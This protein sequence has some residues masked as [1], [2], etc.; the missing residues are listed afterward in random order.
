MSTKPRIPSKPKLTTITDLLE[1][2]KQLQLRATAKKK[3]ML[4]LKLKE[5]ETVIQYAEKWDATV[6]EAIRTLLNKGIE[7]FNKWGSGAESDPTSVGRWAPQEAYVDPVSRRPSM[8]A[9]FT[10]TPAYSPE[11]KRFNPAMADRTVHSVET[12]FDAAP[13]NGNMAMIFPSGATVTPKDVEA[14]Y[15]PP[16]VPPEL[17]DTILE[18]EL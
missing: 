16:P 5:Y 11:P 15:S 1:R 4:T 12:V 6:T 8:P 7:H 17:D 2:D 10:P 3:L 18:A 9:V 14:Q 13:R